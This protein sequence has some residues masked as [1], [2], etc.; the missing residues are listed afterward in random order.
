MIC[1]ARRDPFVSLPPAPIGNKRFRSGQ[2][3][4][5]SR[6]ATN[7]PGGSNRLVS[8]RRHTDCA[9]VQR[10]DCPTALPGAESDTR[11]S[12]LPA[13]A[14][15]IKRGIGS[16]PTIYAAQDEV[17]IEHPPF[18]ILPARPFTART[19]PS[20]LRPPFTHDLFN[21]VSSHAS[22]SAIL[23]RFSRARAVRAARP[24][25][26]RPLSHTFRFQTV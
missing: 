4:N 15:P 22:P 9:C 26:S 5:R 25:S 19:L 21:Q 8:T 1:F 24:S 12:H 18:V 14:P 11:S 17:I 3:Q 23:H 13:Y 6:R 2:R 10:A 20:R 16:N 7:S